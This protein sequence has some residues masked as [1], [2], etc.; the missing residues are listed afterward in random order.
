MPSG[1]LKTK[2]AFMLCE[3][4]ARLTVIE[5]EKA[6]SESAGALE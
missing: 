2:I 5:I 6:L 1:P 3:I 4:S